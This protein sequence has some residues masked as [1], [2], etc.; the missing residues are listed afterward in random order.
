MT[1]VFIYLAALSLGCLMQDLSL[2]HTVSSCC[3][4]S[5]V[6]ALGLPEP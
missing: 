5:V 3:S 4:G 6:V 1:L 2:Q